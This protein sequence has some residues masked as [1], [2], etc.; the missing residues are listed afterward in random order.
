MTIL[1]NK[2]VNNIFNRLKEYVD[3]AIKEQTKSSYLRLKTDVSA[4]NNQ[5]DSFKN[6]VS[7]EVDNIKKEVSRA[8]KLSDPKH[9]HYETFFLKED[10]DT[11]IIEEKNLL[12]L[13]PAYQRIRIM[14]L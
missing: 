4:L 10:A 7:E 8:K 6:L 5:R 13:K 1:N 14:S 9:I 3:E 12:V 2:F 11:F